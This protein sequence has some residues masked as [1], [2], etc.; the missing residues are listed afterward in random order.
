MVVLN[1]VMLATLTSVVTDHMNS[2][3]ARA[4]KL[5][6]QQEEH[7]KKLRSKTRIMNVFQEIDTDGNGLVDHD[8]FLKM[9]ADPLLRS[10]IV[11]ASGLRSGDLVEI[12][13]YLSHDQKER[14]VIRYE[15][16][17]EKLNTEA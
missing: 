8:E 5:E 1:W 6:M 15:D 14:R 12:F 16:F 2:S 17:V 13:E 10:E 4:E 3:T 11:E 9:L 7:D